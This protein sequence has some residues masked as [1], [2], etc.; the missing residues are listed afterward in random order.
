MNTWH[1]TINTMELT[2]MANIKDATQFE[3]CVWC[4]GTSCEP[5]DLH[6]YSW[7]S[8]DYMVVTEKTTLHE[9]VQ[10]VGLEIAKDILNELYS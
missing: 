8:D 7:M 10:W 3:L 4:D 9:L 1:F 2:T 5:S 6:G